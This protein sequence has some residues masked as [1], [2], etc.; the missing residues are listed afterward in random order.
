MR[1]L[2]VFERQNTPFHALFLKRSKALDSVPFTA[3]QAAMEHAGIPTHTRKV[4]M[5]LYANPA[6]IIVNDSSHKSTLHTKSTKRIPTRLS[7]VPLSFWSGFNRLLFDVKQSYQAQ[8]GEI[9]GVFHLPSPPWD[10][11]Y[12]DDTLLLSCSATELNRLFHFIQ[13]PGQ[14][15]GLTLNQD[16]C[17]H[18]RLRSKQRIYCLPSLGCPCDCRFCSGHNHDIKPVPLS[19]EV[20]N[21]GVSL[22]DAESSN[23]IEKS[24]LQG[25]AGHFGL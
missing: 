14:N 25:L 7:S 3:T 22:V 20:K 4:I 12:A 21:L 6:F 10:L 16:K 19:E 23:L 17:E 15:R 18:P 13:H 5:A 11:E 8:Y 1:L 2:E 24:K 9:S